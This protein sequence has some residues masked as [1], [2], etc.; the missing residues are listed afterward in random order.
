M[1]SE[2][3][4][5]LTQMDA[6][7][8]ELE[9]S[10]QDFEQTV[11]RAEQ[12]MDEVEKLVQAGTV[13]D[14]FQLQQIVQALQASHAAASQVRAADTV[15]DRALVQTAAFASVPTV[16]YAPLPDGTPICDGRYCLIQLLHRRPRVH[17]YLARRLSETSIDRSDEQS[18]V[19]I[20]EVILDGLAPEIRQRVVRAAFEEFAAPQLFGSPHFLGVGDHIYL[21]E[22]R[23]Y[24]VMQP[25][26]VRGSRT[27]QAQPLSEALNGSV[28]FDAT[29]ALHLGTQLC[30]AI[31]R[32]HRLKTYL[33]ELTPAMILVARNGY[34]DWAPLLMATWPPAPYFWPG[35]NEPD[36]GKFSAQTFPLLLSAWDNMPVDDNR[37]FAAPETFAGQCDER[38]DVYALGAILYFL[39][40][41]NAPAAAIQRLRAGQGSK[42]V[43]GEH[44]SGRPN[45]HSRRTRAP[46]PPLQQEEVLIPPR[47]LNQHISPL[48]EQILL[49]ALALSPEQRF[50][51][52]LDLTEALR[53]MHLRKEI[54][55]TP[56]PLPQARVSRLRRLL[57]WLKR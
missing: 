22:G 2:S 9:R 29:T 13:Q 57:E 1:D 26:P 55:T 50:A 7:V 14:E 36:A 8:I 27:S 33:G 38:S 24:L 41:G 4:I 21:E 52:A 35:L 37:P 20:R 25:R 6:D 17:L 11:A 56:T 40:T 46:E 42:N 15:L 39:F 53:S 45:R 10:I 30:Q 48:L 54:P 43:P 44:H 28:R 32:L 31:A 23:H 19:A 18:L 47:L 12:C 34:A 5:T 16:D 49:R 51:S 3:Q